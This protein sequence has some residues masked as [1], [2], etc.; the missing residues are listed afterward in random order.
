MA[1]L[2]VAPHSKE[3]KP[4][5][6]GNNGNGNGN[7]RTSS[8]KNK[9]NNNNGKGYSH[10]KNGPRNGGSAPLGHSMGH[11]QALSSFKGGSGNKPPHRGCNRGGG[12]PSTSSGSGSKI[13]AYSA[14]GM[15]YDLAEG[16][17]RKLAETMESADHISIGMMFMP[18][19]DDGQLQAQDSDNENIPDLEPV[20]ETDDSGS[21]D[22]ELDSEWALRVM[23]ELYTPPAEPADEAVPSV[24]SSNAL[25]EPELNDLEVFISDFGSIECNVTLPVPEIENFGLQWSKE[26]ACSKD[27]NSKPLYCWADDAKKVFGYLETGY[28]NFI[29]CQGVD[30]CWH[31]TSIGDFYQ[32][33]T[34]MSLNHDAPYPGDELRWEAV[35][36]HRF[37][38]FHLN[39]D[40]FTVA[41]TESGHGELTI[42]AFLL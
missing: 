18:D 32:Y 25:H 29:L 26:D 10:Y 1:D 37:G 17:L 11:N 20:S 34:E 15:H 16:N 21:S 24:G 35:S 30:L 12:K 13:L 39:E 38:V 9:P 5:Q 3:K 40:T 19:E 7:N 27:R 6:D 4:S 33:A 2:E 22:Y 23:E 8:K 42:S 28:S 41:D 36:S 31:P 14:H